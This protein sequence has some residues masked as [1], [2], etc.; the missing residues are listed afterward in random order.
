MVPQHDPQALAEA[1]ERLLANPALR[2][3]LATQARCLIEAEF[4]IHRNAARLRTLFEAADRVGVFKAA[5]R[6]GV[7]AALEV[8]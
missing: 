5:D 4:D 3:Q 2:V 7:E 6:V 8:R 1:L